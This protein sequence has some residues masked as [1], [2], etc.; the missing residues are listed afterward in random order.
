M[1]L[2]KAL[3]V[4]NWLEE[5][6]PAY[7]RYL[8][9]GG[10][11]IPYDGNLSGDWESG[12]RVRVSRVGNACPKYSAAVAL[13]KVVEP[14]FDN[15][16][17]V[18]FEDAKRRA[19]QIYEAI[20]WGATGNSELTFQAEH[21]IIDHWSGLSGTIDGY[22]EICS[23]DGGLFHAPIE[24]KRTDVNKYNKEPRGISLGQFMQ[25][26]GE[27]VLLSQPSGN[28]G[29]CPYGY[30]YT[31]YSFDSKPTHKVWLVRWDE[32]DRGWY[33]DD[34]RLNDKSDQDWPTD[35]DNLVFLPLGEYLREQAEHEAWMH[36]Y[37]D[38]GAPYIT[39]MDSWHCGK[40]TPPDYYKTNGVHG[41]KGDIKPGTGVYEKRC[42]LFDM[43]WKNFPLDAK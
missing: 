33:L 12:N 6:W 13:G 5:I 18:R 34:A 38:D 27:M 24:V 30:V 25:T 43:C 41:N 23:E 16:T 19:E 11:R 35:G 10:E 14:S 15:N 4:R 22:I 21:R 9:A 26:V 36:L 40:Y 29:Q 28:Y 32:K 37:S 42:P 20:A 7:L 8:S 3:K 17:L 39:P 31:T 1:S 2:G